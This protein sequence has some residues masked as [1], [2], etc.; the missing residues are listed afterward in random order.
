VWVGGAEGLHQHAPPDDWLHADL[1]ISA[2]GRGILEMDIVYSGDWYRETFSY[3]RQAENIK[4]FV[5][6]MPER[7]YLTYQVPAHDVFLSIQFPTNP[8]DP[9]VKE[10]REEFSWAFDYLYEAAEGR[11]R[12]EFA[13]GRYYVAVAF[14]AA[15]IS[16]DEANES[17]D[18]LLYPGITGG[19][20]STDYQEI[21]MEPEQIRS[22]TWHIT[23]A[24]GWA[25][26]WVYVYDGRRFVR[27]TEILRDLRGKQSE[28]TEVSRIGLVRTVGDTIIVRVAEEREEIAFIDQLYLVV[29]GVKVVAE[30]D[31]QVAAKVAEIDQNYL[32][33]TSGEF[34]EFK[35][36]RRGSFVGG[37]LADVLVVASGFYVP[38][39]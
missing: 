37:E 18:G 23:D 26:P 27:M 29:D 3:T 16:R 32:I 6:V 5:L 10:G 13:P 14:I 8:D 17:D 2:F 21:V 9:L 25:C 34:Y 33:I 35:F 36:R 38:L 11:F 39:E 4:H 19:G 22:V 12:E 28:R 1:G 20:A 30:S 7:L 24:D 15:P 31:P